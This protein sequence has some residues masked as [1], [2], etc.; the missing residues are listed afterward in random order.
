MA[1]HNPHPMRINNRCETDGHSRARMVVPFPKNTGKTREGR[2]NRNQR[3]VE[4]AAGVPKQSQN[5]GSS[6]LLCRLATL[7]RLALVENSDLCECTRISTPPRYIW[8]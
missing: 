1:A 5:E 6:Q 2:S 3:E 8:F 4:K 7:L